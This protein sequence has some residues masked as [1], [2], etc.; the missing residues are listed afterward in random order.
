M[1]AP[2][3]ELIAV[4]RQFNPWWDGN[5]V[6]ELP[7]WRR[8]AF[9]EV[10]AWLSAPPAPRALLLSGARQV[11]KTTILLQAIEELLAKGVPATSILYATFD[12]PLLKL[13]GLDGLMRLWKEYEPSARDIE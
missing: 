9:R 1:I 3:A 5:R 12:H 11:G 6:P 4:L 8:A 2:R 13:I 10:E 7:R